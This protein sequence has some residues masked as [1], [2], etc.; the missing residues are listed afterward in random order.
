MQV[1][2]LKKDFYWCGI[3]DKNLRVFD[4]IMDTQ[5]G[6][7]YN[8]YLL[9]TNCGNVLFETAKD[10][11]TDEFLQNLMQLTEIKDI[12][13]LVVNHTEPD[14]AGSVARLLQ[15]NPDIQVVGSVGALNF[16]AEIVNMSFKSIKATDRM[17]LPIGDKT[18][19]FFI[20]P[21]LHWP[22]TMYTYIVQDKTLLTC[23]SY[24]AH[25][26]A[27]EILESKLADTAEFLSAEKYY[28]DNIIAPFKRPYMLKAI[29]VTESLDV[30][31]ICTGHGVVRDCNITTLLSRQKDWCNEGLIFQNKTVVV[32]YVSAYGYTKSMAE[33]ISDGIS[34]LGVDVKLYDI[35]VAPKHE[36]I[37]NINAAHGLVLG[38][39]TILGEA[40]KPIWDIATDLLKLNCGKKRA[41]AFGS[42][43]WSGEGAINITERLKQLS[44]IVEE[45]IRVRFKPTEID[46]LK[47]KA[48][49]ANFAAKV[50]E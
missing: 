33:A 43:G 31:M 26:C 19:Q 44:F 10:K 20:L 13:Y 1:E 34:S 11:F 40:L 45:P 46:L 24:G 29:A 42:Y 38:T 41:F 22:D 5:Y 32:A 28:F 9:K 4:I 25:F 8:S 16:L 47:C 35:A 49:G 30:D 50:K 21:N 48:A 18:L 36:I 14:H 2:Q 17:T 12:K 39:P 7:S 3:L 15:L 27:D 6:T 23:D 37:D